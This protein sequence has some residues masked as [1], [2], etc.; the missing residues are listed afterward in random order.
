MTHVFT[1]TS[2]FWAILIPLFSSKFQIKKLD[3]ASKRVTTLAGTGK[4]GFKDGP[5]LQAQVGFFI[6]F[7]IFIYQ[8]LLGS[9]GS[10]MTYSNVKR[11]K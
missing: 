4:A 8:I 9:N 5:A 3:P 7:L 11:L 10:Q 6:I 2:A 1:I